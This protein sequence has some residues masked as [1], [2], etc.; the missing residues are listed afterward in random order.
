[1]EA[2]AGAHTVSLGDDATTVARVMELLP[3]PSSLEPGTLVLLPGQSA[4]RSLAR[5]VLAVFGRTKTVPRALR[6]SALLARGYVDIG[7]AED[8]A[9][10]DLAWGRAPHAAPTARGEA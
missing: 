6:C 4:S 9:R 1:V 5:S 10:V 3:D 8:D 7:A 2:R